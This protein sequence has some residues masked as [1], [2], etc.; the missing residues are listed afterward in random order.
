MKYNPELFTAEPQS[1][2]KR[3]DGLDITYLIDT[4]ELPFIDDFSSVKLHRYQNTANLSFVDT[5]YSRYLINGESFDTASLSLVPT[6]SYY[7][8]VVTGTIDTLDNVPLILQEFHPD[9]AAPWVVDTF[10]TPNHFSFSNGIPV[11]TIKLIPDSAFV[12]EVEPIYLA[13]DSASLWIDNHVFIN[14][15]FHIDAPTIGVATFDGLDQLGHP[16]DI[17]N[18]NSYGV[19][20]YL[21]SKPINLEGKED[22]V[23]S[24]YYQQQGLGNRPEETDLLRLE[25]YVPDSLR[26][27]TV[28]EVFGDTSVNAEVVTG[29]EFV[30]VPV[31]STMLSKG[32]KFRFKNYGTL[33]GSLDH[34]NIDYVYLNENRSVVDEITSDLGFKS[35]DLGLTSEYL[36]M[37]WHQ[38]LADPSKYTKTDFDFTITNRSSST[39]S[40]EN[41][42]QVIDLKDN[43]EVFASTVQ[44]GFFPFL[45]G[46]SLYDRTFAIN[47]APNNF[48]FPAD[49][50][51]EKNFEVR[52]ATNSNS[53]SASEINTA[54]DT[55]RYNQVFSS[56]YAYDD[57]TPEKAVEIQSAGTQ[58]AY[59]FEL[60]EADTLKSLLIHFAEMKNIYSNSLIVKVWEDNGGI[61]GD[62][63]YSGYPRD[64][65]YVEDTV[66]VRFMRFYIERETIMPAG[67]FY[68]GY[69]QTKNDRT[70]V[71]FDVNNNSSQNIM[72]N[73][74]G[75]WVQLPFEGSLLL[76][77]DFGKANVPQ[78]YSTDVEEIL[79]SEVV[80][81]PNPA[82][83]NVM[84][85]GVNIQAIQ[86]INMVGQV[87]TENDNVLTETNLD[88]SDV[89]PGFYLVRVESNNG[90]IEDHKLIIAR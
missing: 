65:L 78:I 46:E 63:L 86:L 51:T 41:T 31:D 53:L 4:L 48:T 57:G 16:Y 28:W 66:S 88:V 11:D 8:S 17:S 49:T 79:E 62:T 19:A 72:Y 83:Q 89:I 50:D 54:N 3:Y 42:Y 25:Y 24:F 14:N 13:Y 7:Y 6:Q 77:P 38:Y 36:S 61:P 10:W 75:S 12:N 44:D 2:Q 59:Q 40:G 85:K 47:S 27:E 1:Q 76:R 39:L 73:I 68:V 20:D 37:P 18:Q 15:S 45:G 21:T 74:D 56:Y 67:K 33:S 87:V 23:L 58:I 69:E 70:T 26:W 60:E 84:I 35:I 9:S 55:V 81:Y 34:W 71:G 22:V 80:I 30:S 32:F 82:D 90:T 43:T 64:T 29:F 52:Y 5:S